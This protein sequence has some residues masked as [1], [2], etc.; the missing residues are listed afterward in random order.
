MPNV[1]W[2]LDLGFSAVKAVKMQRSGNRVD[3]VDL[4]VIDI[5]RDEDE[6]T[7]PMRLQRAMSELVNRKRITTTPV[8]L[9][10]PGNQSFFRPFSL[11]PVPADR[12]E[13]IVKYE[14]RQQI[15]FPIEEVEWGWQHHET[16]E[17]ESDFG[18]DMVAVRKDIIQHHLDICDGLGLRLIG[19]QSAPLGLY[20]LIC[21]EFAPEDTILV[22]DIG[23]KETDFLIVQGRHWWVRPLPLGGNDITRLLEQKFRYSFDEAESVK[24]KMAQSKQAE[25]IFQVVEPS[26][27]N[28]A[29]E[30]QRTLGYYK[31]L[32]RGVRVT[33]CYITGKGSRLMNVSAF[34]HQFLRVPVESIE[35]PRTMQLGRGAE[36]V[37]DEMDGLSVAIGMGLQGLDLGALAPT[38][39]LLPE[40]RRRAQQIEAKKPTVAAAVAELQAKLEALPITIVRV[41]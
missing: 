39:E 30:V 28:L 5:E 17:G 31:S 14:A 2:S 21:H 25:K 37:S 33:R 34:L 11:P 22:L 7:R 32:A 18:V 35:A 1:V 23:A 24:L 8:I 27:R 10:V 3:I 38:M 29:S 40:E 20:N 9:A 12:I 19:I 13:E 26:L 6:T 4:A 36:A 15:P 16:T 41:N